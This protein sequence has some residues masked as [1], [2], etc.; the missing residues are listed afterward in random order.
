M[1]KTS[2]DE[3]QRPRARHWWLV[4]AGRTASGQVLRAR[5]LARYVTARVGPGYG[6]SLH[7]TCG[8]RPLARCCP[9]MDRGCVRIAAQERGGNIDDTS[10]ETGR[11]RKHEA[12]SHEQL[13]QE[14]ATLRRR[15]QKLETEREAMCNEPDLNRAIKANDL[16][17]VMSLINNGF[18]FS[19]ANACAA[20]PHG[21]TASGQVLVV[22]W[23]W[24]HGLWPGVA[25]TA[26]GQVRNG[27]G[28]ARVRR[29]F[30]SH[31]WSAAS[32]QVL[33]KHGAWLCLHCSPGK[34]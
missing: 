5:L 15:L 22:G 27:Q 20:R 32:G 13:L 11:K 4:G 8:A 6:V 9:N 25:R 14:N 3:D 23:S 1:L 16:E 24:A 33:P 28:R 31:M 2:C 18:R 21:D 7:P 12:L 29:I 30:A 17:L 34:A 10:E 19:G 26:S